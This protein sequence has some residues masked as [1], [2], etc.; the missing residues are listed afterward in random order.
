LAA[1]I[2]LGR[3]G[4]SVRVLE[5]NP[6]I[7]GGARSAEL[8]RPGLVHDLCSAIHPLDDGAAACLRQDCQKPLPR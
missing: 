8:T 7:G 4:C 3:A 1:A 6:A 2:T 5:A